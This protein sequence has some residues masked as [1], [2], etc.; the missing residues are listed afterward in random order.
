MKLGRTVAA[1]A[2]AAAMMMLASAAQAQPAA[3][4]LHGTLLA[5]DPSSKTLEIFKAE[6]ERLSDGTLAFEVVTG[7]TADNARDA[8]DEVR[9][10]STF[11]IVLGA[12]YMSRLVP[13]IGVL[14]LP[15][16][17]DNFNQVAHVVKGTV[18]TLIETKLA[19]KG[20]TTLCWMDWAARHVLNAKRPLKTPGDFKGLKLRVQPNETHLAIFRAIGANPVAMDVKDLMPALRQGDLDGLETSYIGMDDLKLYEYDKYF[21]N[22]AHVHDLLLFI[23]NRDVFT[24]LQPKEQT[25]I[26]DAAAIACPQQVEDG[27]GEG[28][29]CF[30]AYQGKGDAVRS[31][32]ARNARGVAQGDGRRD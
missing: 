6:A 10:Q 17:F 3:L 16:V 7:T 19:A 26:R 4:R 18:G 30:G 31:A 28:S 9:T 20:F 11:G 25:A 24:S 13:E 21:S 12:S 32:A 2:L 5:V 1:A 14:G 15:F 8:V 27:G 29:G 23:V 22:S